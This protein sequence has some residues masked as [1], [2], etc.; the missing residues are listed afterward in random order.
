MK[1]AIEG[2]LGMKHLIVTLAHYLISKEMKFWKYIP[3]V[4]HAFYEADVLREE[5]L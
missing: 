1:Q 5:F 4:L 3:N 2:K